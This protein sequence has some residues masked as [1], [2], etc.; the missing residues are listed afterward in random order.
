MKV[1]HCST[2][3]S[4][5]SAN[6][7]MH[8]ALLESGIQS[9]IL[10]LHKSSIDM[11]N[12]HEITEYGK[13]Y[14]I[15]S[16]TAYFFSILEY[17]F[18]DKIAGAM[19]GMPFTTGIIGCNICNVPLVKD[20]DIIHIHCVNGGF[21]SIHSMKKLLELNKPIVITLHDSWFLTGGCHVLNGCREFANGCENCKELKRLKYISKKIFLDK[22]KICSKSILLTAPSQWTY[23]N[24]I[25]SKLFSKNKCYIVGNTLNFK[26]FSSMEEQEIF[27]ILKI[28]KDRRK[29]KLLFGAL[30]S[31]NTP[32]KGFSYL[33]E[34]LNE[35]LNK[36]P[37]LSQNVELNIFGAE[38]HPNNIISHFQYKY[39]GY[40]SEERKLAAIYNY[41]DIFVVPSLE[42]SFNQTV[43][44]SCACG[45]P[46]V[47]FQTGGI[48]D[49]IQHKETGYLAKYKDSK[50]LLQGILWMIDKKEIIGIQAQ[51][52]VRNT[53]AQKNIADKFVRIY[54]EILKDYR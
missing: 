31:T 32:Y 15:C 16:K 42:D 21:L 54:E 19:Q 22:S 12:V 26:V 7:R 49:I 43:L 17:L 46:V 23:G 10:T 33:L 24:A 52:Y 41:S 29:I 5:S 35:M 47:S 18:L 53:F 20:A 3:V 37:E 39:W 9:D 6:Y 2:S 44:E 40:V 48:C 45:T 28:K 11:T 36:C 50:D 8:I 1:V 38:E 14:A 27:E 25:Q 51:K 30:N 34:M 4:F 13:K